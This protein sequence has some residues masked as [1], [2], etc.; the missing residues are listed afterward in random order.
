MFRDRST[1]VKMLLEGYVPREVPV[2]ITS[3]GNEFNYLAVC[4][5]VTKLGGTMISINGQEVATIPDLIDDLDLEKDE[6][7]VDVE[8]IILFC[9]LSASL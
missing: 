9:H 2:E 4:L 8:V 7:E 5:D 1:L 6:T 3:P